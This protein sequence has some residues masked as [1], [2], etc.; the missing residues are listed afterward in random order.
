[1]GYES[2]KEF[3]VLT[4]PK[5]GREKITKNKVNRKEKIA[6]AEKEI[7]QLLRTVDKSPEAT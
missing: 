4:Y 2:V 7:T 3:L 6:D 5:E 1:M